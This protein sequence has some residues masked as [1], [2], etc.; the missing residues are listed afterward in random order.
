MRVSIKNRR[1]SLPVRC[2]AV[3][4]ALAGFLRAGQTLPV[5]LS[6]NH[7]DTFGWIVGN[8]DPD[9]RHVLVLVDAHSDA[10]MA[11]RSEEIREGLR[12]VPSEKTRS[13][14][15]VK[16]RKQGRIQA[17]NWIEPLM[18]RPVERVCW[19]AGVSLE[20]KKRAE[21]HVQAVESL[22][23]RLEVEPRSAGSLA[24]RWTTVDLKQFATWHPGS[25]PVILAV[26]LDFFAGMEAAERER[27]FAV[28]WN[29][30]LGWPGLA[31]VAFAVSRPWLKDD[32]EA[33]A[34]VSMACGAVART[35]GA[36]LEVDATVDDAPD[37]SLRRAE[38]ASLLA[39]WDAAR[40]SL[41]LRTRWLGM[42]ARLA[43]TDRKRDWGVMF[44]EWAAEAPLAF[45]RPDV[46]EVDCDGIWRY[47]VEEPPVLRVVAAD[48]ATGL[49][50]WYALEPMQAAYDLMPE[51]GLGKGFAESPGRWVGEMRREIAMTSDFALSA[52]MWSPGCAG[53]V[54]I[55]A[56]VET[57]EGWVSV[58]PVEIR[59]SSGGGFHGALSECFRMP[60][61]FGVAGVAEDGLSGV[62]TGWG[63]DCSNLLIYA[64]R[65]SGV[66]LTWGDPGRM[67]VQ[68]AALVENAGLQD[69]PVLTEEQIRGGV[70]ID[71]GRHVAA[72]W[73]DKEP[74][75][76]LGG[77]DL[78]VHHLG[79]YPEI[80]PLADLTKSRP[81]FSLL[82][83]RSSEM[84]CVVKVAGD[85]VLAGENRVVV[86][87]FDKGDAD[88]LLVNLEGVP[89]YGVP[90]RVPRY[91]FR[92]PKERLIWLRERG[93]D[94]VSFANN[95]AGDAGREGLMESV[96]RLR[97][98]GFG[99]FGAGINQ[100]EACRPWRVERGGVRMA[101]FGVCLVET[102][103]ATEES[104][105]VA[106]LP[107]HS[108][109]I[110]REITMARARGEFV[111]VLLHGGD[112]YRTAVNDDQRRWARWLVARGA[113]MIAGAHPHVIQ[114]TEW[115]GGTA[116]MHSLGNAVYPEALANTGTGEVK[117]FR[118]SGT[119]LHGVP[120]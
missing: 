9:E 60:Y 107:E 85:V 40:A 87:G 91:D 83:P 116:I 64:W 46:G 67:R 96:N 99:V 16:W 82:V 28:I 21:M 53:R 19:V 68:L 114:R 103:A 98:S 117:V 90:E 92:F 30:A 110:D 79:G 77:N 36:V 76:T 73:E 108:N 51:T 119:V 72:V 1:S 111:V 89:S 20:E 78:V 63:A 27:V 70:A 52:E 47:A 94:A 42:R 31:G 62:E 59:L 88:L 45:I 23:G 11:E 100:R 106:C 86:D 18:P 101:V 74:T 17:Y 29:R 44:G 65:R 15:V 109:L 105:G 49:V 93:V 38:S 2:L 4:A 14:N 84:E 75:G 26:D 66:S 57:L 41:T 120:P 13:D 80:V 6:D 102:M 35:R 5:F 8:F 10:S 95:H 54:R 71:F 7:A 50:R 112:E 12:R 32:E 33:D 61:V 115:H 81:V 24:D 55:E 113:R 118:I 48:G 97:R 25:Q 43:V 37:D 104:E 56:E 22:D 58:P 3:L 39:R 34:L 69:S